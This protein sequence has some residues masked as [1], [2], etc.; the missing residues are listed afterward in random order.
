MRVSYKKIVPEWAGKNKVRI[1]LRSSFDSAYAS[2]IAGMDRWCE[3]N[4]RGDWY[5][6]ATTYFAFFDFSDPID[7]VL[8]KLRWG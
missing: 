4:C 1:R 8:F 3:E 2:H 7:S 6:G 5:R